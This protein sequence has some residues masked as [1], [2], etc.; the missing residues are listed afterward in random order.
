MDPLGL[1]KAKP[2]SPAGGATPTG[3]NPLAPGACSNPLN[4]LARPR[5]NT[6]EEAT[7]SKGLG[8][9]GGGPLGGNS[10]SFGKKGGYNSPSKLPGAAVARTGGD[11]VAQMLSGIDLSEKAWGGD[12]MKFKRELEKGEQDA[13]LAKE[14]NRSCFDCG[15]RDPTWASVTYGIVLC[16]QCAGTHRGYGVHVSFVRSVDLDSWCQNEVVSM[17][18]G[19]NAVFDAFVTSRGCRG[20][21][22]P[23]AEATAG[24]AGALYRKAEAKLYHDRLSALCLGHNPP[25]SPKKG[26]AESSDA[27]EKAE[28][29]IPDEPT[30]M[31]VPR[32]GSAAPD[33]TSN[34]DNC[35]CC[36][37]KFTMVK[38]RHHCRRCGHCVCVDCAP[39]LNTRPIPEWDLKD[40]VRHCKDC[41][42]SPVLNW[43][44]TRGGPSKGI[45]TT[46]AKAQESE[47]REIF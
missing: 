26:S 45:N 28:G 30:S 14:G 18:L 25:E 22:P 29:A 19:G 21:A 16:L 3:A 1:L 41:F 35:E 23:G 2:A 20:A 40:P 33:C 27:A 31:I 47:E 8:P 7:S 43:Q 42:Q 34:T 15:K 38:R 4:P 36:S 46:P 37:V 24:A 13:I 44:G 17:L 9:L 5:G 10:T 32:P 6:G 12:F 39:K 11:P